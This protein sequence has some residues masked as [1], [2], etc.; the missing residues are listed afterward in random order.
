MSLVQRIAEQQGAQSQQHTSMVAARA[1][2]D[3][4]PNAVNQSDNQRKAYSDSVA[5]A[6]DQ[7]IQDEPAE[8]EEQE[9]F[10]QA[11]RQMAEIIYGPKAS[12]AIINAVKGSQDVVAGVGK[13]ARE[14]V[15]KLQTI[16]PD[17]SEDTIFALGETAVEQIVDLVESSDANINISEDQMAEA[18]SIGV[19]HWMKDNPGEVDSKEAYLMGDAPSQLEPQQPPIQGM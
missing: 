4:K 16:V 19:T 2:E 11:E 5:G 7:E 1:A 9:L 14:V 13:T 6:P 8:P 3:G 10:T 15:R 12:D 18:L 17:M